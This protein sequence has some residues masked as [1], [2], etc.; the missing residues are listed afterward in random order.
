MSSTTVGTP[1]SAPANS[2]PLQWP[3]L[4][5]ALGIVALLMAGVDTPRMAVLLLIGVGFG[6]ALQHGLFGFTS[7]YRKFLVKRDTA[8]IN[9]QL[10]L[11]AVA[12]VLFV[13][14]LARGEFAG[15]PLYGALA[16]CG[17]QVV[18]GAFLFGIGMQLG[19]GCG[20]GTLYKVGAGGTRNLVTLVAF[21]IGCFWATFHMGAWQQL[22][23]LSI[24]SLSEPLGYAGAAAV[25]LGVLGGLALFM[26]RWHSPQNTLP[27][28]RSIAQ[29]IVRGPWSLPAA[30]L[31]LVALNVITLIIAGH[32]WAI[33]WGFTLWAAKSAAWLGWDPDTA[34]FWTGGFQQSA[35]QAGVLSDVTS[36]MNFGLLLG[37]LAAASLSGQFDPKFRLSTRGWAGALLGGLLMGYGARIAYGCN[38]GAF[39][40]G[41][42]SLSLHGWVWIFSAILGSAVGVK[43]RPWFG[44]SNG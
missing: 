14:L 20:S 7:A 4:A 29:K 31:V 3:V 23:T 34:G 38:I 36:V 33:T 1:T 28:H 2:K 9:A 42:A 26:R 35:L 21:C 12:T 13:P 5:I 37:A 30:A 10:L 43:W 22:P 16:P 11:L 17:L 19:D 40:S 39:F 18:I 15:Q 25:Q 27:D 8:G 44:L 32:P 41:I 6:V 24:Y